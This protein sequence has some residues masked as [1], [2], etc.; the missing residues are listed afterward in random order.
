M[1]VMRETQMATFEQAAV[2]NFENRLL[3]HLEEF[4]PKHCEILGEEQARKAIR[5]GIERAKQYDLVSER[6]LHLYVG[7]MFMLGSY[8]DQDPQ[9]PWAAKILTDENIVYPND[10]ADQ[11]YD[12]AMVF[13]NEAVGKE[14]Q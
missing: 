7:L 10:R 8:F 2:H 5:L 14:N 6:D 4:F 3:E 11:L 13:L 1:L 9:L 12:R